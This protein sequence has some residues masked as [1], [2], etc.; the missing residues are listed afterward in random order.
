MRA[1]RS[2]IGR[3]STVLVVDDDPLLRAVVA[4][5][6][7]VSGYAVRTA[8]SA[9]LALTMLTAAPKGVDL[10]LSD[11]RMPGMSGVDLALQIQRSWPGIRVLLMSGQPLRELLASHG[12]LPVRLL[13]KPFTREELLALVEATLAQAGVAKAVH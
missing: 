5:T 12:A 2:R 11:V 9:A 3:A 7:E 4:R 8:A 1:K 13:P 10:V 6:L